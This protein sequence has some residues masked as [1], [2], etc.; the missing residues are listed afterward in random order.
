[1]KAII[2]FELRFRL[3]Q[4]STWMFVLILAVLSF[5]V[6]ATDFVQVGGGDGPIKAAAPTSESTNHD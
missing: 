4:I 3:R 5:C 2:L 1:M 6:V